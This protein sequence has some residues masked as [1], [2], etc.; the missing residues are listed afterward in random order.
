METQEKVRENRYRRWAA[1]LHLVLKR[2]RARNWS[3]DNRQ[4][5]QITTPNDIILHGEKFEL[6][7]EKVRDFLDFHETGL[8][9][10]QDKLPV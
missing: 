10:N 7:L 3:F 5:Y 1:R 9:Q 6:D 4:G 2:S 8:K